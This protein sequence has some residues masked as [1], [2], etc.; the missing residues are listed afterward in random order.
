MMNLKTKTI[1]LLSFFIIIL[2]GLFTQA[3]IPQRLDYHQFADQSHL[4]DIPH[5]G[6]VVTNLIFIVIGLIG[7]GIVWKNKEKI[8][9]F[10]SWLVFFISIF[11]IGPGSAYYHWNPNNLTLVWDRL[12]MGVGFMALYINLMI[13]HMSPK[14]EKGLLWACLT[15]LSSVVVWAIYDD[16]RFY[17]WVQFSSIFTIPMILLFFKS[18]QPY[19]AGYF[20]C[21]LLYFLSKVTETF[22]KN[23]YEISNETV[24]GHNLKHLLAGVGIGFLIRMIKLRLEEKSTSIKSY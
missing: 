6:D 19:R 15:G 10:K 18:S 17:Y 2:V 9:G 20:W 1:I 8:P 22:D 3:P 4:L 23:I 24:S 12:P 7:T 13:E 11:L 21:F 14:W 16:L 5:F